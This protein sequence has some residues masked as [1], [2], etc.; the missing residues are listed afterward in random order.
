MKLLAL[1]KPA[2]FFSNFFDVSRLTT[3]VAGNQINSETGVRNT[4]AT[5]RYHLETSTNLNTGVTTR[6]QT[7]G[8]QVFIPKTP[9]NKQLCCGRTY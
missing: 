1:T 6:Y 7:A 4:L 8:Y 3:N 9:K 5:A 2:K